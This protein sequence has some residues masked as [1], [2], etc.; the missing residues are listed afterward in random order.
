M[1][2][3][4]DQEIHYRLLSI[5]AEEP[6]LPQRDLAGRVGI[7]VGKVNYCLAELTKKGFIKIQRFKNAKNRLP[8]AY[9]LTPRGI[10]E[11]GRIT[12]QFLKRKLLE[13][14]KI[15][16]EIHALTRDVEQN[17]LKAMAEYELGELKTRLA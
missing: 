11:K 3:P 10:E 7:S 2:N 8:Y 15:Q 13:Y 17:G 12:I 4:H 1:N 9:M 16:A 14:D 6:Q 5:L